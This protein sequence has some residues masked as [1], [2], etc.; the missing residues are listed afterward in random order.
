MVDIEAVGSGSAHPF[1]SCAQQQAVHSRLSSSSSCQG[2]TSESSSLS[3]RLCV[4]MLASREAVITFSSSASKIW[5]EGSPG[6]STSTISLLGR[7]GDGKQQCTPLT[8]FPEAAWVLAFHHHCRLPKRFR[9]F[10]T[11]VTACL[12]IT[13]LLCACWFFVAWVMGY[14][15]PSNHLPT[16]HQAIIVLLPVPFYSLAFLCF[17]SAVVAWPSLG[18]AHTFPPP[19]ISPR[20]AADLR[21][22]QPSQH[23]LN[24]ADY[25]HETYSRRSAR[26]V[27]RPMHAAA[28]LTRAAVLLYL[29]HEAYLLISCLAGGF[30]MFCV[31]TVDAVLG[32]M[33]GPGDVLVYTTWRARRVSGAAASALF[34]LGSIV[35]TMGCVL[36]VSWAWIVAVISWLSQLS[37]FARR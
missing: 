27:H 16:L 24:A 5:P 23:D 6:S 21:V 20:A 32:S 12:K 30:G 28:R 22:K 4:S 2:D 18:V 11:A 19:L 10:R 3:D 7:E 36:G 34:L 37:G 33:L 15:F 1:A 29:R 8:F 25:V 26:P 9:A 17:V 13:C 31:T 35:L 14:T